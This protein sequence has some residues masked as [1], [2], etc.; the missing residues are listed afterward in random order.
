MKNPWG[1]MRPKDKPYYVTPDGMQKVL[2]A[3]GDPRKPNARMFVFAG[4]Y[5]EMG[6][7]YAKDVPGATEAW[8]RAALALQAE[9]VGGQT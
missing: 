5:W 6:D 7:T 1:K 2:K 8:V 3:W 9:T 4:P